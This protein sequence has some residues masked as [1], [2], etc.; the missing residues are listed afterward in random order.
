MMQKAAAGLDMN[1]IRL[2]LLLMA[3][4]LSSLPKDMASYSSE[5]KQMNPRFVDCSDQKC[6]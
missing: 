1:P 3:I 5:A 4:P 2:F 6:R